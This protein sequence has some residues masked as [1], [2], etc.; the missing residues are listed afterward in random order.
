MKNINIFQ[1]RYLDLFTEYGYGVNS[2][3]DIIHGIGY[4]LHAISSIAARQDTLRVI[5]ELLK[6]NLIYVLH[7]GYAHTTL[8]DKEIG[9]DEAMQII[10]SQWP[11]RADSSHISGMVT[12]FYK[13]WYI[14]KL[15]DLGID[16][17]TDWDWFSKEIIPQIR[18]WSEI[19]VSN[20]K[21]SSVNVTEP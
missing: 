3:S 15:Q 21:K 2:I 18:L 19:S 5:E 10:K 11:E 7:W 9:I 4:D 20:Q 17:Y 8:K 13:K 12:F 14:D 1:E 6:H 16:E